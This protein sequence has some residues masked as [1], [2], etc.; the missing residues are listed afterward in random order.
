MRAKNIIGYTEP[1][2]VAPGDRLRVMVS[3]EAG[4]SSYRAGIVRLLSG[5]DQPGGPGLRA[6][7]VES[8]VDGD[9]PARHQPVYP[10][11]FGRFDDTPLLDTGGDLYLQVVVM[12]TLLERPGSTIVSRLDETRGAGF[13][14]CLAANGAPL[15]RLGD[16]RGGFHELATDTPLE[17]GQWTLLRAGYEA[18]SGR[19]SVS[20]QPL[21]SSHPAACAD[22]A[23]GV[24]AG[25]L[26]DCRAPLLLAGR[27]AGTVNGRPI[28][29]HHW[30]GRIE[31]PLLARRPLAAAEGERLRRGPLP[32]ALADDIVLCVDLA[33]GI[34]GDDLIDISPGRLRGRLWS[35]PH[36]AVPCSDWDG[37]E[38]DWRHRPDHYAAVHFLEDSLEDCNWLA[39][40]E[41]R[42]PD[43]LPSGIYA[44]HLRGLDGSHDYVPFFVRPPRGTATAPLALLVPTASYLAYANVR[45]G[46]DDEI[47][48]M[49]LNR[50]VVLGPEDQ[51][52][53]V[54]PELGYSCYDLHNDGSGVSYSTRKR[55]ILNMRPDHPSLWQMSA[56]MH[57]LAWLE[58]S[59]IAYDV[60]TDE[61]LHAEGAALLCNYRAV[62]TGSHPEYYSTPMWDAVHDWLGGGGRLMYM[63]GNGFYWRVAFSD[64][65]PGVMEMRR[66]E[67][68]SRAWVA[69]PGEYHLSYTGEL[70][71]LWW[72]CGRP[73]QALVGVGFT[74]QGF[75][76]SSYFRRKAASHDPRVAWVFDG[77][78]GEIFGDY[79]LYG[80]GAA[81]V[82]LDFADTALGTPAHALVLA[83]SENH[84]DSYLHVN[85]LIGHMY[86]AIGGTENPKVRAD[87]V[88]FETGNGGAVWSTG[89]IA[90]ISALPCNHFDNDVARITGNVLRR[91]CAAEPLPDP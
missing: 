61:D 13:A 81:G 70:G 27:D 52:L 91:F 89:S 35:Q 87:M 14:L 37:S 41:Y 36:R 60:I 5:D 66:A 4:V 43:D 18:A 49:L 82:E 24:A 50:L 17:R 9:Y 39:D 47:D 85:E 80:G 56:D 51:Y 69:R 8:P 25:A 63:G 33:R 68:G 74:A 84:T 90:W 58:Q 6:A 45:T 42:L 48:E 26:P 29:S 72:R 21:S 53:M 65:K 23:T 77:V 7:V 88:F 71:G 55:P 3:C 2:S 59:A 79:G 54:H 31:R 30:N 1:L 78:E 86:P 16:G 76:H 75:D 20:A 10:G 64:A 12:P 19:L 83:S 34:D 22:H 40:F 44:A 11:S 62:I 46:W 73:P 15:L 32:A 57:L 28:A 38:H 67:D